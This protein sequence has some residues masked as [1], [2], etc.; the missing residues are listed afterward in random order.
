MIRMRRIFLPLIAALAVLAFG[1]I[2]LEVGPAAADR[3][4]CPNPHSSKGAEKA[5]PHSAHGDDKQTERECGGAAVTPAAEPS[6]TPTP[7]ATP[8]SAP[9][10]TPTPPPTPTPSPTPA[11]TP[12]P[13]P[14]P[15]PATGADIEV[16]SVTVTPSQTA[17]AGVAFLVAGMVGLHNNG[18]DGPVNVDTTL[19]IHLPADCTITNGATA[20]VP[21]RSAPV[22]VGI[23]VSRA[24]NVTC[25]LPG[26][27]QFTI[28]AS[29]VI[30]VGQ[31]LTDPNP[32]NN[33]NSGSG[34][35]QVN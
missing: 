31:T 21:N 4:G 30:S 33:S 22:S 16:L 1:L 6:A 23:S 7:A 20:L 17:T 9:T 29:V 3:G 18:P 10:D 35:A 12:A 24:W 15:T 14:S 34:S 2:I 26:A 25:A 13:T 32:A 11:P 19:T 28:D 8:T 27:H 5:N